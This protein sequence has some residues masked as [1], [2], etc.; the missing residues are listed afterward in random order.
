MTRGGAGT[1]RGAI[2]RGFCLA[3]LAW[4]PHAFATAT[5]GASPST[6]PA[7]VT[8]VRT[9]DIEAFDVQGVK[10]LPQ[11]DVERAVY[12]FL[13]PGRLAEDV[14]RA[15][16][17]LEKVYRDRGYQSVA[18]E[19]PAQTLSDSIARLRVIEAP[20]GRLRV[21]GSRYFSPETIRREAAAF[22]EGQVPDITKAQKEM[23]EL[24]RLP[25]RRVTPLLRA[26]VTPGTV[27][28]DLKVSDTF[29][30]H[31]S[32][33]LG[34][35]HNQYTNP[36]RTTATLHYDNLWQLGHSATF[37][38]AVAPENRTD[39]EVFAGSYLAP[40][41]NSP[42]NV[43][44]FGYHSNSNVA[45][46]GGTNVLGKGYA[47]GGR[48][49]DQLP[50]LGDVTQSLSF[51][52]DF[53][54]FAENIS[55]T[56][57]KSADFIDYW[58]LNVSYNIER[59]GPRLST[60][61]SVSVT[62]GL[63]G[64]GSNTDAFEAKRYNAR[65]EFVHLNLDVTQTERLWRGFEASEHITGQ[66]ADGPMVSS[67]QL[68]AG[69]LTSVL[70]YLQ[71]EAVGDEGVTGS[72]ELLSPSLAPRW[73]SWVDDVRLYAFSDGASL[74]VLQPLPDQT[75]FFALA[76]AG[77]GLRMAI[78]RR[79]KGD[80]AFGMPFLS[81]VATRADHPRITFSVKTDF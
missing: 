29:P 2:A 9:F 22:Q 47:I 26:G 56:A 30:L 43:L 77:F 57:S 60:K 73:A 39:S 10:L 74:W 58:P 62:A 15:R 32:V 7:A 6:G 64:L 75:R 72:V 36:L 23:V 67:E 80:V 27:D 3:V 44:V 53:K 35:D 45:T 59:D 49:I 4:A 34:N 28:V 19:I 12:P 13:G 42:F 51:G 48:V 38:Y 69:G 17:A 33:E 71:S 46:L 63:P 40:L 65:P 18:V 21:V 8:D 54:N 55:L 61:A 81:G 76:S 24:N 50:R 5:P 11:I 79:L 31:G 41:F 14:E 68:S 52:I 70:G 78:L 1:S 25:D 37:T 20:V 16:A 66:I